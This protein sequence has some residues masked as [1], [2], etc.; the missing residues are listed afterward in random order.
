MSQMTNTY[1]NEWERNWRKKNPELAKQR[2]KRKRI[3]YK[4]KRLLNT[5]LWKQRNKPRVRA[6]EKIKR[7]RKQEVTC[8][9]LNDIV[10]IYIHAQELRKQGFEV[11]VDHIIPL[12]KGGAHSPE[13]LQIIYTKENAEKGVRLDYTPSKVF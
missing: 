9:N 2:D 10:H 4:E 12:A 1:K 11:V 13:N 5:R 7:A 6:Y 8:G 3:K